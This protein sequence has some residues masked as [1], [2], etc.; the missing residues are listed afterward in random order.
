MVRSALSGGH[1][2]FGVP[3]LIDGR[4]INFIMYRILSSTKCVGE[5]GKQSNKYL[6]VKYSRNISAVEAVH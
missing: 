6:W 1:V 5:H 2:T 3:G 4:G